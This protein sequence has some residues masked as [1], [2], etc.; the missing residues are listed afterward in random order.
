MRRT[1]DAWTFNYVA[2]RPA[3]M[4]VLVLDIPVLKRLPITRCVGMP[5]LVAL[6]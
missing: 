5:T 1:R 3:G 6:R 4:Q 2:L